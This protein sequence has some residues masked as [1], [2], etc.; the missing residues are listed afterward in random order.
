METLDYLVSKGLLDDDYYPVTPKEPIKV[1]QNGVIFQQQ[2]QNGL[3]YDIAISWLQKA[4]RRGLRDQALYCAYH[5]ASLGKIFRSHLCNRL[6]T[7][8]SEDIGPAEPGLAVLIEVIY[9]NAKSAEKDGSMDEMHEAI[10][11]MVSLLSDSRKSRITDWLIHDSDNSG[12]PTSVMIDGLLPLVQWVI[13]MCRDRVQEEGWITV[14]YTYRGKKFQFKKKLSLYH[15][16]NIILDVTEGTDKYDDIVALIKLFT[17][18][19]PLYGLLHFIH[20]AT[21]VY[22]SNEKDLPDFPNDLPVW[23]DLKKLKYPIMNDSVDVHTGYGRRLLGRGQAEFIHHGSKLKNWTPFPGEKKIIQKLIEALEPFEV[24]DSKPRKYQAKIVK[25]SVDYLETYR[26]GWLLM[27]C[28]TGKTK[29][30]YWIMK[31]MIAKNDGAGVVVVVTPYLQILRQFHGSW[32]A[33]NRLHKI[34]SITGILASCTDRY[35]KDDYTNYE[36]LDSLKGIKKFLDYPD[37]VKYI[38]TTYK[39]LPKLFNLG[40]TPTIT[41]YDEAHHAKIN[42]VFGVGRELFLTAT[43]SGSYNALGDIIANYNLNDAI[44]DGFLTPYSIGV[45]QDITDVQ[46]LCYTQEKALKTIVYCKTNAEARDFYNN[47]KIYSGYDKQ[48][49]YVDC[50]TNKRERTRIFKEY[51]AAE[52]AVIF[53][54]AI[55]GEGVDITDCD[56]ILIQSGYVSQSRVVQAMGRPLRLHKGKN[57]AHIFIMDDNKVNKRLEAMAKYDPSVHDHVVYIY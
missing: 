9:D 35:D 39:S 31:D 40:I 19:G 18:R 24:E 4:I 22:M 10:I 1:V 43:P 26:T 8:L 25:D 14:S 30:S 57:L 13:Y 23:T 36:Y 29:T 28:G 17:I 48:S 5:I 54:C 34:K 21:L 56:S 37:K 12:E 7:I 46:G 44:D 49:F 52:R 41:V 20:A 2:C 42:N 16:W 38:Y 55:L 3:P 27:A 11:K 53:N 45:L 47:W 15:V 50:K 33:M 32:S 51:R 6:I